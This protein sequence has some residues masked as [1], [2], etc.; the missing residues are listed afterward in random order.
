MLLAD[1]KGAS[2]IVAVG[3]HATLVEFLDKGRGGMASTFLTR[4]KVGGKL[5]DA[6]GVSRL[7][8]QSISGSSLLLLVLS[9]LAAMASA[10]A[11]ST[12]GKAYLG[13]VAE[14][15]DN[16]C[17]SSGS[18]SRLTPSRSRGCCRDQLSVPRGVADR[19]LPGA[20][21][22][23]GGRHR[24]AQRAGRRLAQ[25]PGQRAAQ[26]QPADARAGQ[27][28]GDGGAA[29][30][31]TSPP[32][33]PR[34]AGRASSTGRRV[35]VLAC[36]AAGTT[37]RASSRCSRRPGR[38]SPA[39]VDIQ[40][41]FIDPDEQRRAAGPGRTRG[42]ADRRR[43]RAARQQRRRGD[44]QRPAGQ[45]AAGPRRRCR[46]RDRGRPA[47]GAGGVQQGRLP[48]R[49]PDRSPGRREAVVVVSGPPYVD[50][51]A[52][53]EGRAVVTVVDQFDQAGADR[54]GRQR[55]AGDG[56]MVAVVRGDPA[57]SKT[58]STVD[59]ANTA[60][61]PDGHRAGAGPSSS[62]RKPAIRRTAPRPR[63]TPTPL[64]T[65]SVPKRTATRLWRDG[66]L[67]ARRRGR[68]CAGP[69]RAARRLATSR[70]APGAGA[71]QLPRPTVS[72]AAGPALA[73]AAAG[74]RRRR[75]GQPRRPRPPRWWPGSAPA[76][77]GSTTT[78][79]APG[80]SRRP[81]RASAGTS[82]R[83]AQGRVTSGLVKIVGVGAA[84]L[85]AA[86]LLAADPPSPRTGAAAAAASG[87]GVD[88]LL[89][90]GVIAGTAN[91]VNLLD[92]RPGPGAQ[93]RPAARRAAG[94]RPGRRARRRAARRRRRRCSPTTSTSR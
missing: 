45:R 53:R 88:V 16:L 27:Q 51:D 39:R 35:L 69:R 89:G 57:L 63:G 91:L 94:A 26:G 42:P 37:P 11:V 29:A 32:R 20:G 21:D 24:R 70:R 38:R 75:R 66:R 14:W 46:P 50:R 67:A 83:C 86:A 81:P 62:P 3:T 44:L 9:A 85:A 68:R 25:G 19:G 40:D 87:R 49:Q 73:A 13:V 93:G 31:R 36:P 33:W 34:T 64:P 30:R 78:W 48:R 72:L 82:P 76:R 61:G 43:R 59:N 28:P 79:S 90:A 6:K 47:G 1:E 8:R 56:N 58:I 23:P 80:R 77:S 18:S 92:L 7:Y 84:G 52:A 71:D 17:S 10:V 5:V 60:A 4:L 55:L 2:L 74:R 22:R 65:C 41:K 15:W 12:V 54:G